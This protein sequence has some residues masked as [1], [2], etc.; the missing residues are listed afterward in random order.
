[1]TTVEGGNRAMVAYHEG[2]IGDFKSFKFDPVKA[3]FVRITLR[4]K[5]EEFH[6]CEVEVFGYSK[7]TFSFRIYV[8]LLSKRDYQV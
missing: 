4:D 1:V 2:S 7:S 5:T 8:F 3:R 6:L